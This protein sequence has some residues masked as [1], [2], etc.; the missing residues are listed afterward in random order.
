MGNILNAPEKVGR[1]GTTRSLFGE[2]IKFK[3]DKFP[4]LTTK[5]VFFKGVFEELM[6]FIRGDTNAKKLSEKD[7]KIWDLNTKKE[8]IQNCGLDYEE[9]DMGP[10]Y[11]FQLRHFNAPYESMHTDYTGQGYDQLDYVLHELRTNPS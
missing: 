2:M 10:M 4:L 7:V 5:R 1:N 6:F 8:F 9:G 3:L 11:G